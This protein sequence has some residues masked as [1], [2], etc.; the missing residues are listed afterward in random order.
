VTLLLDRR[1]DQITITEEAVRAATGNYGNRKEV[2]ALLLDQRGDKVEISEEVVKAAMGNRYG[3]GILIL[4]VDRSKADVAIAAALPEF[5]RLTHTLSR[6]RRA[7]RW[8][9]HKT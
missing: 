2:M 6:W 1:R 3:E 4:L 8:Y 5:E 7:S 9:Y